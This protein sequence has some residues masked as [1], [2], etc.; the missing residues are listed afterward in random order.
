MNQDGS[1]WLTP[2]DLRAVWAALAEA[3]EWTD[4]MMR[5]RYLRLAEQLRRTR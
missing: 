4:P 2:D 1:A 5:R 3:A